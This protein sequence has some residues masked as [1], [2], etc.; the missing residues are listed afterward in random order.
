MRGVYGMMIMIII[1]MVFTYEMNL[2]IFM[3][4]FITNMGILIAIIFLNLEV[5]KDRYVDF[6]LF[7]LVSISIYFFKT[8]KAKLIRDNFLNN[9]KLFK[10]FSFCNNLMNNMNAQ[11]FMIKSNKI[12]EYNESFKNFV[13]NSK[14]TKEK[15]NLVKEK[16]YFQDNKK[17]NQNKKNVVVLCAKKLIVKIKNIKFVK[18]KH[19]EN[20]NKEIELNIGKKMKI[21]K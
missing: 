1:F 17:E 18:K 10:L 12:E 21:K 8:D 5:S 11:H 15:E 3:F 14:V 16:F 7:I 20:K 6:V 4:Y 19:L 13:I 9:N 2:L